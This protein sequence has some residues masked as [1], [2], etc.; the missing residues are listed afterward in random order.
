MPVGTTQKAQ[1]DEFGHEVPDP[2]PLQIPSGFKRPETLAEQVQRL[3][4]GAISRQAAEQ[5]FETFEESEDFDLPDD[6]DDPSTP[7]EEYFDP[8][9]GRAITVQ[10]FRDNFEVYKERFVR[11]EMAA[12]RAMDQSE[13][14]RRRRPRDEPGASRA[15]SERAS[16]SEGGQPASKAPKSE[17]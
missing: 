8:T 16:N 17:G 7:Y 10:E 12:W 6:P 2:T 5:G 15:A 14:L 9:L 11:A 4:R 13:A 1:L 3:V